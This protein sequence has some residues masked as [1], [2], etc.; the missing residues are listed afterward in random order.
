M[1]EY[2]AWLEDMNAR[3]T[4]VRAV[5]RRSLA[6]DP[7]THIP[8]FPYVESFLKGEAEGWR[9]QMHYLVAGL[10][11]AHWREGRTGAPTPLAK[12]CALHHLASGSASTERHFI[13]LLDAD[14]EQLPHRLRQMVALLNA[15][16]I[17]F[18]L[19]LNDLLYWNSAEKGTQN[20]WARHFYR[21][22]NPTETPEAETETAA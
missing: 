10:W 16:P 11:A 3:D 17:D 12:A 2:I 4:K 5:L 13:H 18:Q 19:L 8:V 14:R 21:A 15:Q 6:F 1:S 7:G 9:R 20:A 22:L